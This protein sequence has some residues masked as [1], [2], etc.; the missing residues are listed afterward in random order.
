MDLERL[1]LVKSTKNKKSRDKSPSRL[2]TLVK[3]LEKE[4]DYYKAECDSLQD[5]MR[6]R[7]TATSSS[8]KKKGKTGGKGKVRRFNFLN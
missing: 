8:T 7:L 4:R 1:K 3:T 2:E 6:K 5:M